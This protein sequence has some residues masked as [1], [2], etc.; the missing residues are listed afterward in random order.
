MA[1]KTNETKNVSFNV[2][3]KFTSNYKK[4]FNEANKILNQFSKNS[5]KVFNTTNQILDKLP[6]DMENIKKVLKPTVSALEKSF[7]LMPKV[8]NYAFTKI[9]KSINNTF[10]ALELFPSVLNK[11]VNKTSIYFKLLNLKFK[12]LSSVI[13][14]TAKNISPYIKDIEKEITIMAKTLFNPFKK[15]TNPLSNT[16]NNL[17]KEFNT[18]K[19]PY[20]DKFSKSIISNSTKSKSLFSKLDIEFG[21]TL[22]K[23]KIRLLKLENQFI[24]LFNKAK[25]PLSNLEKIFLNK[26]N[27]IGNNFKNTFKSIKYPIEDI[28]TNLNSSIKNIKKSFTS[29]LSELFKSK[30]KY[31]Y[32]NS[33]TKKTF[34]IKDIDRIESNIN[35]P[36]NHEMLNIKNTSSNIMPYYSEYLKYNKPNLSI[37]SKEKLK[38]PKKINI[39]EQ[40]IMK[41]SLATV[42]TDLGIATAAGGLPGFAVSAIIESS[43][44]IKN[45][46]DTYEKF[47][48][49]A[50]KFRASANLTKDSKEFKKIESMSRELSKK[51]TKNNVEIMSTINS[52]YSEG[53]DIND[54]ESGIESVVKLQEVSQIDGENL[55]KLLSGAINNIGISKSQISSFIDQLVATENN[56][57]QSLDN[58]LEAFQSFG[59]ISK[60]F[61]IDTTETSAILGIM[62]NQGINSKNSANILKT[63]MLNLNDAN[64]DSTK[65]LKELTSKT[66]LEFFDSNENFL[67]LENMFINLSKALENIP[68][69]KKLSYLASIGGKDNINDLINVIDNFSDKKFKELKNNIINS[70]GALDKIS[71]VTNSTYSVKKKQLDNSIT[72]LKTSIGEYYIPIAIKAVSFLTTALNTITDVLNIR[73]K[74]EAS[75]RDGVSSFFG[76]ISSYINNTWK[77]I[78]SK[79]E[80]G[81]TVNAFFTTLKGNFIDTKNFFINSFNNLTSNINQSFSNII[82]SIKEKADR[83]KEFFIN[84]IDT[85][86]YKIQSFFNS[87]ISVIGTVTD[88]VSNI[89]SKIF[90][91]IEKHILPFFNKT[92]NNKNNSI[93]KNDANNENTLNKIKIPPLKIKPSINSILESPIKASLKPTSFS[94]KTFIDNENSNNLISNIGKN[95]VYDALDTQNILDSIAI[96]ENANSISTN[97]NDSPVVINFNPNISFSGNTSKSDI[98]EVLE[99]TKDDMVL[100]V[101][102]LINNVIIQKERK[103][104]RLRNV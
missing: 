19:I 68:D 17:K 9:E 95:K 86:F 56:S 3:A 40:S 98:A 80:F 75:I 57:S 84:N 94:T 87:I 104:K 47:E 42:G 88:K 69:E 20:N 71:Q 46:I 5:Q 16:F 81:N 14:E 33:E 62:S 21:N 89:K 54:I 72:E 96:L 2:D 7:N 103:A 8:A 99:K 65:D 36:K 102:K 13:K 37:K 55:S 31:K 23:T 92:N 26:T 83:A 76:G 74:I 18:F 49:E 43:K 41:N 34:K 79:T 60:S 101:E 25:I 90:S 22:D 15:I 67:G 32:L 38:A 61:G 35:Y 50:A 93:I 78:L 28:S 44:L 30:E 64:G 66:G 45:G 4:N 12:N 24:N 100:E 1:K 29:I 27:K 10:K 85:V 91:P 63:I 73:N 48:N 51:S 97:Q 53:W 82:S 59:S 6:S 58:L 52:L 11:S 70:A 39:A 77:D